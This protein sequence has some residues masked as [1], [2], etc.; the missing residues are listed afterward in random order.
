M[1]HA[2]RFNEVSP[3]ILYTTMASIAE[4]FMEE[5]AASAFLPL[6]MVESSSVKSLK[7]VS[8]ASSFA[9]E[10]NVIYRANNDRRNLIEELLP[11]LEA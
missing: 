9:L 3:P 2:K 10:V 11:F 7:Q 5:C 6:T 1:F 8:S 4:S